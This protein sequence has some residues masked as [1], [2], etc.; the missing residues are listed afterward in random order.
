MTTFA[1]GMWTDAQMVALYDW[2]EAFKCGPATRRQWITTDS[3]RLFVRAGPRRAPI[4]KPSG[5]AVNRTWMSDLGEPGHRR[6]RGGLEGL[7]SETDLD[8]VLVLHDRR[9]GTTPTVTPAP[10]AT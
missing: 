2:I 6:G 9:A 4:L 10:P 1:N 3:N 8:A 5:S 7:S